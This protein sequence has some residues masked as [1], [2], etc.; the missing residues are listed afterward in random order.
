MAE[1]IEHLVT[2]GF[3]GQDGVC[4]RELWMNRGNL[5]C[6]VKSKSKPKRWKQVLFTWK[7]HEVTVDEARTIPGSDTTRPRPPGGRPVHT[8]RVLEGLHSFAV[9]IVSAR[10]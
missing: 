9:A 1:I 6:K 2:P 10:G 8:P 7:C 3:C 4:L 5:A